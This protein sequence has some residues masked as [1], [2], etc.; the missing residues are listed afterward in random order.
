LT[1]LG[2]EHLSA[3]AVSDA[4]DRLDIPGAVMGLSPLGPSQQMRGRAY[5]VRYIPAGRDA[6][7]VGDYID[8]VPA[9]S[10]VVL[11]NDGRTDCTVWGDILT[12]VASDRGV[13]G[14]VIDG[15][16]RDVSRALGIGYPIY[17]RGRFM[18]TG[19]DRVEVAEVGCTVSV[20]GV[21][22]SDGDLII[23]DDDG[24]VVV[25]AQYERGVLAAATAIAQ[26]EAAILDD[27]LS[28]GSLRAARERHGYHELQRRQET[29]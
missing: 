14:T 3:S 15:V 25:P 21:Q 12:A 8:D 9:G 4:L 13:A 19:K 22:V 17:S 29:S 26:R 7:T 16:C 18:R 11:A 23:G 2:I 5:T 24:V 20:G 10:V 28:S 1:T 6:G 27:A